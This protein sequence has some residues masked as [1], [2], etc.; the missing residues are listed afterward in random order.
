MT[1]YRSPY[2]GKISENFLTTEFE[3]MRCP[4]GGDV[5]YCTCGNP[6]SHYGTMGERGAREVREVTPQ[7]SGGT[8][9]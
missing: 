3:S 1:N 7:A 4:Q 5:I 6:S 9:P 2:S 8:E